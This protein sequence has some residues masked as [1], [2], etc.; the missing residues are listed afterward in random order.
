MYKKQD[1]FIVDAR[2]ENKF[3]WKIVTHAVRMWIVLSVIL[4]GVFFLLYTNER[5]SQDLI[6]KAKAERVLNISSQVIHSELKVLRGDILYLASLSLLH[7]WLI[8]KDV[9]SKKHVV[10]DLSSFAEQ[11]RIYDQ[12]RFI[13]M[14]G[15]EVIRINWN[16]DGSKVVSN[17]QLQ[18]KSERYYVKNTLALK[19]GSVYMSKFDLNIEDK[20][21]EIPLKPVI[22]IGT[23]VYDATGKKR[24]MFLLNYL[25]RRIL[26][27]LNEMKTKN[28]IQIWL[29]NSQ[30]YWL[31]GPDPKEEWGFAYAEKKDSRFDKKYP[32]VWEEMHDME[33]GNQIM[34]NGNLFSYVKIRTGESHD[35][36]GI[37]DWMLVTYIPEKTF[38]SNTANHLQSFVVLYILLSMLLAVISWLI[39]H[40]EVIKEASEKRIRDSEIQFR[41]LLNSAPDAIIIIDA[42]GKIKHVNEQVVKWFG[43]TRSE[44]IGEKIEKLIPE[45]YGS[46]HIQSRNG[47]L[48]NP[49]SRP[50]GIDQ[51]LFGLRRDGSEFPV[52]I[53]LSPLKAESGLLVTSIIRD[54]SARK[55]AELAK[56]NL[57]VRYQDL[58]NNLPVGIYRNT[59]EGNGRFLEINPAM[60]TI[61]EA[62][63]VE[64]LLGH[65][66]SELYGSEK[67]RIDFNEKISLQ[68]YVTGEELHLKTLAGRPFYASVTAIKKQQSDGSIYF[69]GVVEDIS[70][71]KEN[72]L[73]I[74][75]LNNS[76][77]AR[78]I[79]METI[80]HELEAFSYSVSHD[81]RAPLRAIDGFS[82]MLINN[83]A[84][85]LD[86][87]GR[88]RLSRI[89]VGA[90]RMASLIDDLLK[91]SRVSRRDISCELVDLSKISAAVFDEIRQAE[92]GRKVKLIITD[93]LLT[94]ADP[95]LLRVAMV[96]LIGNAWK[97]TSQKS[98]AEIEVGITN[99]DTDP[100][101]YVRDNGAGFD[102]AYA[103]KLFGAFQRL[104]DNNEFPGTGI[105]LA[106]VQ[107]II[108]KHGGRIWA[109]STVGHGAT[110]HFTLT[111]ESTNE[112]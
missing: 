98:N 66:V 97:F 85:K 41:S 45:R 37:R 90:Q 76:L 101:F 3:R 96:N 99:N 43:Y 57:E 6:L 89:R 42:G 80:N 9:S 69:D 17:K 94:K 27:Q 1:S 106:T 87:K 38:L 32:V 78:S 93:S 54:I 79:E 15:N 83:Y 25:G 111:Q 71:R 13:D 77:R 39:S 22:R 105:G 104:H 58:I 49:Q 14:T 48:N 109:E 61:F 108:N 34:K 52:E 62:D 5:D 20:E 12:I 55:D 86:D 70:R 65:T 2:N 18:N 92:P 11:R 4:G 24:G 50:M 59:S 88:D 21:I 16:T 112:Q 44:L 74:Q 10:A 102:M 103:D 36:S 7:D 56:H 110:F 72:E 75:Q 107:R 60:T 84:E 23:P 95:Q 33:S 46:S 8:T 100:H 35:E 47:Y 64:Q 40:R 67:E 30:G 73:K 31:L 28:S 91:L 19:R 63:S 81:L 26:D 29:L 82:H 68:G 51:E 53:S